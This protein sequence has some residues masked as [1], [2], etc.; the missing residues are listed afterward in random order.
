MMRWT[1]AR[2]NGDLRRCVTVAG[3]GVAVALL[4]ACG[5]GTDDDARAPSAPAPADTAAADAKPYPLD[6]CIVSDE[7]LGSMGDIVTHVHEGQ[8]VKFCCAGCFEE[9]KLEPAKFLAKLTDPHAGHD[10]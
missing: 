3:L 8:E 5:G 6:V 4:G 1:R 9:F 10:H 2:W 7:K